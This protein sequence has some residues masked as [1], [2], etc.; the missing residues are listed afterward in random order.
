MTTPTAPRRRW[1]GFSLRTLF[2]MVAVLG[3]GPGWLGMMLK[4]K[5]DRNAVLE[6]EQLYVD[7]ATGTVPWSLR[8][9]GETYG[10]REGYVQDPG[11]SVEQAA[12]VK[13]IRSLFP[14][15]EL[16]LVDMDALKIVLALKNPTAFDFQETPLQDATDYLQAYHHIPILFDERALAKL[17]ISPAK[18]TVTCEVKGVP[19][20]AML[21]A[22]KQGIRLRSLKGAVPLESALGQLLAHVHKSLVFMIKDQV[23]LI[24]SEQ[25]KK[26]YTDRRERRRAA[27]GARPPRAQSDRLAK[28]LDE[29]TACDFQDTPLQGVADYFM[30]YHHIEITFDT[31]AIR[32]LGVIPRLTLVKSPLLDVSL[33]SALN[34]ILAHIDDSLTYMMKGDVLVITTRDVAGGDAADVRPPAQR[35]ESAE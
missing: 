25:Q 4:W 16:H 7:N 18:A 32:T 31:D 17:D 33:R 19:A 21:G 29:P 15:A 8:L 14:E 22:A 23:L 3:A 28:A 1:L 2:V 34:L 27:L 11:G 12:R 13:E 30:E 20:Q 24:T 35:K 10:I 26:I 6:T 9:F 5:Q